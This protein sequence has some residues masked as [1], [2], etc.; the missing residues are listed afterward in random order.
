MLLR[1]PGEPDWVNS[2]L[3][4]G[5]HDVL[6]AFDCRRCQHYTVRLSLTAEGQGATLAAFTGLRPPPGRG[7]P[8]LGM[9]GPS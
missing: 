7:D 9:P 4:V 6:V 2:M 3:D 1:I 8:D 5:R